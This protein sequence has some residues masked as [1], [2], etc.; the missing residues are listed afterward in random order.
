[1]LHFFFNKLKILWQPYID[2]GFWC[3][4]SN[5]THSLFVSVSHF[6]NSP[7]I[8]NFFIIMILVIVIGDQWSLMLL[9]QKKDD[10]L[11]AEVMV[12]IFFFSNKVF[13]N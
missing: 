10:G 6:G 7:N 9:L 1:M 12:S 3:L 8:S 13:F 4:F 2:H 5:S 11:K